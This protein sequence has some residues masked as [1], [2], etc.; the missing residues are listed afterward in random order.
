MV[1]IIEHIVSFDYHLGIF[2]LANMTGVN[3]TLCIFN[4]LNFWVDLTALIS[5]VSKT[6]KKADPCIA[7][8]TNPGNE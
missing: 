1:I 6:P 8:L 3:Q 2:H 4:C 5:D 7:E